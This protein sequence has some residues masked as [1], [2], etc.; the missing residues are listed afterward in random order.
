MITCTG[1]V[2]V[3]LF[4]IPGAFAGN[5]SSSDDSLSSSSNGA[6]AF[7]GWDLLGIG[8]DTMSSNKPP[9]KQK[10]IH[11]LTDFSGCKG[12]M[13]LVVNHSIC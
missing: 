7:L 3:K 4:Y 13:V 11:N 9:W 6:G 12:A 5:S 10:F 2:E 8:L 1:T